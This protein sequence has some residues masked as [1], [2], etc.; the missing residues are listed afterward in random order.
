MLHRSFKPAKCKTS[1][2]LAAARM[3]LLKNKKEAQWKQLKRELAQLLESGQDQT[4][5]IR[6]EHVVR[7]EKMM[8]AYD[9][10]EIY[11][12]L[13]TA[14]LPIIEAQKNCPIDLKE[15]ITS[16][17]FASPRCADI[18]ELLDVRKHFTA[19]YGKE[20]ITAAV[21][22]RPE[23]GVNRMLVEKLSA[24]APD[25][26][27]KLKILSAIAEE[28]NIQWDPQSFGDKD[29]KPPDDLLNGPKTFE[30][31]SKMH[32]EPP[33]VQAPPSHDQKRDPPVNFFDQNSRS[34]PSTLNYT[35]TDIGDAKAATSTTSHPEVRPSGTGVERMEVRQPFSS[36]GNAYAL[37]R[38]NWNMEFKDATS[39]AQAAAE[40]AERASMA[41]R[42]AAELSSLGKIT[43]QYSTESQK[44][45]VYGI[46]D[47]GPGK[48][49]A[50]KLRGEHLATDSVNNSFHERNPKSRNERIYR[51]EHDNQ[52]AVAGR[53][54]HDDHGSPKRS[55]KSASLRS[56]KASIAD[57]TLVNSLQKADRYSQKSSSEE[58]A[59]KSE[60]ASFAE[61]G[62]KK[63]SSES[64]LEFVGGRQDGLKSD[65]FDYFGEERIR[66][67]SSNVSSSSHS[68]SFGDD[69]NV[70]SS[71]SQKFG[72]DAGEDPFV[73]I[74]RGNIHSD[75]I[76][77][78]SY[79]KAAVVF[80]E[81]SSDDDDHKFDI[82]PKYDEQ[83]SKY[84][85]S[86]GIE[87]PNRLSENMDPWSPRQNMSGSLENF[88]SRSLF[89]TERH[90]SPADPSEQDNLLPVTFDDS[91]GP[92]SES[93]DEKDK[94]R[95]GRAMDSN[96]LSRKE[97]AHSR[98]PGPAQSEVHGL[99]GSSF[100]D[101]GNSGSDRERWSHSSS[102]DSDSIE[103]RPKNNRKT[104]LNSD[105]QKK[106]SFGELAA[107]Q[108]SPRV[109]KSQ[110][111][112]NDVA[113]KS[114]FYSPVDEENRQQSPQSS[115][116][117][118]VLETKDNVCLP[119]S[120]NTLKDN[121]CLDQDNSESGKELN[122]GTLTG[123]LRNKGFIRPPY[124]RGTAGD[125]SAF[126]KATEDRSSINEESTA[127]PTVKS[128]SNYGARTKVNKKS[129]SRA[130]IEHYNSS[131]DDSE[132][133]I[134]QQAVSSKREP[135]NLKAEEKVYTNPSS[136]TPITYFDS[137][138]DD[139]EKD[140]PKQTSTSKGHSGSGF[141]RRT[142][143]S[144]LISETS[145]YSKIRVGSEASVNSDSSV[146]REPS[147]DPHGTETAPKP[148]SQTECSGKRGSS[149]KSS[150]MKL[151]ASKPIPESKFSLHEE[152][153]MLSVME[154]PSA[155]LRKTVTSGS[156]E[157]PE[158]STLNRETPSRENPVKTGSRAHPKLP[159][160][161]T[162]AAHIQSLRSN[163]H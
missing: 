17:V 70:L 142:K 150:S 30:T 110:L 102:D 58:E 139:S 43:R 153:S 129:S 108:P 105:P 72:N 54:S 90:S 14:R 48:Y 46:Q 33:N 83:G 133:E 29:S 124:T 4:A 145:S 61:M 5:F 32:V 19:K 9:L 38:Q 35:S 143:A 23:C 36:D 130:P 89:S 78:I 109:R 50:S 74:D 138:S 77:T 121:E 52:L 131:S 103:V 123:G 137:D 94:S 95:R 158:T 119:Q 65:N 157:S 100:V 81:S 41:A 98:N 126:K 132:E 2:K 147:R 40:S 63:K 120:R 117:S 160:Y 11:C 20:F 118:L 146:E 42:A 136:R 141:S 10:I 6:V 155:S 82:G 25:G 97:N 144:P 99:T 85:P 161:D 112:L 87:S 113:S 92:N 31:A 67:Q 91:D 152:S 116:I 96:I 86:P 12:E 69:Y 93:E 80:D 156:T 44:S 163:Q 7:E 1:L 127:S 57:D 34:S 66:K 101:K 49:A 122:F 159:D 55:S 26:Q 8:A 15:A 18:T 114:S 64:E 24:V 16:V 148:W 28:H 111:E 115:R 27:T 154:Q 128:S 37:G 76:Q 45:D 39:A 51:N 3:K 125:A 134:L 149:E 151:G 104:E 84:F 60:G 79:D 62:M 135:Y 73:G 53:I 88:T 59:V 56:S 47:E 71:N 21:E 68:N 106:F 13:I 107:S 22:L 75:T 140:L 162:I